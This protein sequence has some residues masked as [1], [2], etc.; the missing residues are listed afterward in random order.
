M[1]FEELK[2]SLLEILQ[3]W[4]H[5]RFH[6]REV[7]SKAESI[8]DQAGEW[9]KFPDSDPRSIVIEV[10][11]ELSILD[12][13]LIVRQDIPTIRGFLETASGAE[14]DGWARWNQYWDSIDF[15]R[16]RLEL[17]EDSE[18]YGSY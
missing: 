12:H 10:L 8:W 14:L 7:H 1:N 9:P 18:Y 2:R 13:Q 16:R 4:E 17:S 11:H 6:E 3:L 5:G 15:D